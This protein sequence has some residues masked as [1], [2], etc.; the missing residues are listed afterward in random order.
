MLHIT[1]GH[2]LHVFSI[3]PWANVYCHALFF[4]C[5]SHKTLHAVHLY[6]CFGRNRHKVQFC[7]PNAII[8]YFVVSMIISVHDKCVLNT[9]L[10]KWS[11]K[12]PF[13]W[14]GQMLLIH[15]QT[16]VMVFCQSLNGWIWMI[17]T[18]SLRQKV[19]LN[20]FQHCEQ[21]SKTNRETVWQ[22]DPL[23]YC[24]VCVH[25]T[26][27][28]CPN[29]QHVYCIEQFLNA[30]LLKYLN[31]VHVLKFQL[32]YRI[33]SLESL[34]LLNI[35]FIYMCV[36]VCVFVKLNTCKNVFTSLAWRL[37][38]WFVGFLSSVQDKRTL[39]VWF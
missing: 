1:S 6:Y 9:A 39:I 25:G 14:Q 26:N 32:S 2:P 24:T 38:G 15:F 28:K 16:S 13:L 36:C 8:T 37:C 3:L 11:K 12:T 17:L 23:K 30:H 29:I 20:G 19:C 27:K 22:Q 10:P 21:M 4:P 5:H 31:V 34:Y 33:F 7:Q 18:T 35:N